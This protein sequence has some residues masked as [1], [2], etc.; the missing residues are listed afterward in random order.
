M[1]PPI[2]SLLLTALLLPAAPWAFAEEEPAPE[3]DRY[4]VYEVPPEPSKKPARSVFKPTA[5]ATPLDAERSFYAA[6]APQIKLDGGE[7]WNPEKDEFFQLFSANPHIVGGRHAAIFEDGKFGG[8]RIVGSNG[9]TYE[10][11]PPNQFVTVPPKEGPGAS[12]V[13][14]VEDAAGGRRLT[15][16]INLDSVLKAN[17]ALGEKAKADSLFMAK[18]RAGGFA[19]A[20]VPGVFWENNRRTTD[21]VAGTPRIKAA[22]AGPA[23]SEDPT[24]FRIANPMRSV[25]ET[26]V[27][28]RAK[29]LA[30]L[31]ALGDYYWDG[32]I[33][34]RFGA[35][36][37][38]DEAVGY[39]MKGMKTA[40]VEGAWFFHSDALPEDDGANPNWRKWKVLVQPV[41]VEAGPPPMSKLLTA[42]ED[43]NLTKGIEE[44]ALPAPV[45]TKSGRK[46]THRR[47]VDF[48]A[49]FE[50]L[51]VVDKG[52]D[53]GDPPTVALL[54][55][56][57]AA[58][59][60]QAP[61]RDHQGRLYIKRGDSKIE[62]D[63][64]RAT[65]TE[66][67]VPGAAKKPVKPEPT[68]PAE[69]PIDPAKPP[70]VSPTAMPIAAPEALAKGRA[71]LGVLIGRGSTSADIMARLEKESLSPEQVASLKALAVDGQ[72]TLAERVGALRVLGLMATKW[73]PAGDGETQKKE[74]A[75]LFQQRNEILAFME[76]RLAADAAQ[77]D[78]ER[79]AAVSA[80]GE[81]ARYY[82]Q[83]REPILSG[84]IAHLNA[85]TL[86]PQ[87]LTQMALTLYDRAAW[88]ELSAILEDKASPAR[89]RVALAL[90]ARLDSARGF[91]P[92]PP[93]DTR[94]RPS[95]VEK[96][97]TAHKARV[98]LND[99]QKALAMPARLVLQ[100][101]W[102]EGGPL[103]Q[104]AAAALFA[105]PATDGDGVLLN[106]MQNNS[107]TREALSGIAALRASPALAA[108]AT[109]RLVSQRQRALEALTVMAS[110]ARRDPAV[111]KAAAD[112]LAAQG[113][114]AFFTGAPKALTAA[115]K[116]ETVPEVRQALILAL[117]RMI[118]APMNPY[119]GWGIVNSPASEPRLKDDAG[120]V[121][122]AAL[123]ALID[124]AASGDKTAAA[125]LSTVLHARESDAVFFRLYF[126]AFSP[127]APK[128]TAGLI[129]Q[130]L[131]VTATRNVTTTGVI[132]RYNAEL[133]KKP[134]PNRLPAGA[135]LPPGVYST[136]RTYWWSVALPEYQQRLE[137]LRQFNLTQ[138]L[139]ESFDANYAYHYEAYQSFLKAPPVVRKGR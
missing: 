14:H 75:A 135:T 127:L 53:D 111:R 17:P 50:A 137:R 100:D 122:D 99:K 12:F 76:G 65:G 106:A 98:A 32:K 27:D 37:Q 112:A 118:D 107:A 116:T 93:T 96:D 34:Y 131:G 119:P 28:K 25:L 59:T 115:L 41:A 22:P 63:W 85:G 31:R 79:L 109:A 128:E 129:Q 117:A 74:R 136:D 47:E 46:V 54:A 77:T 89:A 52:R 7:P 88:P 30:E 13:M 57:P 66:P 139:S 71:V 110:D 78:D 36:G 94:G 3:E 70:T 73:G 101:V 43:V 104:Q 80:L 130:A 48:E 24:T 33:I 18:H 92:R 62:R 126:L 105:M 29:Q 38:P 42:Y 91:P 16:L 26:D 113:Q 8:V 35:P 51:A 121:R 72:A 64:A 97:L 60:N 2:P 44:T 10:Y 83:R 20:H 45:T 55:Q 56:I 138:S 108:G 124:A 40:E 67:P 102:R 68:P 11:R 6:L 23:V 5:G 4:T 86:S 84:F 87:V 134:P 21:D 95:T 103:A 123:D 49:N 82:E 81:L 39:R 125:S 90:H 69:A 120:V 58:T 61:Y 9:L 15:T 19:A 114:R 132:R 1:K 133:A